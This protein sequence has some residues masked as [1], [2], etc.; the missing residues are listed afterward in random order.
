MKWEK[1][2]Q[3]SG[4]FKKKLIEFIFFDA[5]LLKFPTGTFVPE[6]TDPIKDKK[7]YRLNI[8]LKGEDTFQSEKIIF[9]MANISFFRSDISKHR[10][11]K[12]SKDTYI[13]SVGFAI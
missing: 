10:L 9:R 8:L 1:G 5:Y 2:R 7:H 11:D 12:V 4:Y 6:H 13:L 3:N